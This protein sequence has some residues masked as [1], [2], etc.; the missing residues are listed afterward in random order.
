MLDHLIISNQQTKFVLDSPII[1]LTTLHISTTLPSNYH[2]NQTSSVRGQITPT[3][4]SSRLWKK[5]TRKKCK[6]IAKPMQN[7]K[8]KMHHE[9][10]QQSET[11]CKHKMPCNM[12]TAMRSR[13]K[14]P[15]DASHAHTHT[16]EHKRLSRI[17][18]A[19]HCNNAQTPDWLHGR[20]NEA[21]EPLPPPSPPTMRNNNT[22]G[23]AT[24]RKRWKN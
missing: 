10:W 12:A 2:K 7:S 23:W 14:Y 24:W 13:D 1:V 21:T 18:M 4:V 20:C 15:P 22:A 6:K 11:L 3:R 17:T 9:I 16:H 8:C 19:S 5:Q